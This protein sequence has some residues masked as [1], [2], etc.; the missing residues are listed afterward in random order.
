[1][2]VQP[3]FDMFKTVLT[4]LIYLGHELCLLAK[5]IDRDGMKKKFVHS[6]DKLGGHQ[7]Q[8]GQ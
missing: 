7:I 3:Q 6:M 8:S 5:V 1:M 2:P 4:S